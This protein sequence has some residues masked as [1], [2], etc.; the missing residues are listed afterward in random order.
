MKDPDEEVRHGIDKGNVIDN[1]YDAHV[2]HFH[3]GATISI[4]CCG[5]GD[6]GTAA[7][8]L[9]FA[10]VTDGVTKSRGHDW[11]TPGR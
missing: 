3:R 5:D 9:T 6:V 11:A 1:Q 8:R 7:M 2:H 4:S 10:E